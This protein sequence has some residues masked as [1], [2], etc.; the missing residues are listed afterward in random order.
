[1]SATAIERM[2]IVH[3]YSGLGGGAELVVHHLRD[4]LRARGIDAR[5]LTSTAGDTTAGSEPDFVFSGG[6]GR[7]RALREVINPS[8]WARLGRVLRDFDPECVYLGMF[9]TQASPVILQRLAKRAVIWVPNEFR[10]VCP[11]GTRLLPG[12]EP[13]RDP[14]GRACLA[15]GCFR[16]HGLAPRLAQLSLLHRWLPAIDRTLAPSRAFGETLERYGVRVDGILHR[17]V[18]PGVGR[19]SRG[20]LP[21][22][23]YA[24]RLVPEKGCDIAIRA[25]ASIVEA[26]PDARLL[27]AG[28]GPE[29]AALEALSRELGAAGNVEFA[30]FLPRAELQRR[31]CGR[32]GAMCPFALGRAVRPGRDRGAGPGHAGRGQ[33]GRCPA[34]VRGGRALRLPCAARRSGRPCRRAAP[35]PVR[36][37]SRGLV[38]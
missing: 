29:R 16:P 36:S 1:M 18:S 37:R 32:V 10:P 15:N 22:V 24:G 23:A 33:C 7:L 19:R 8:A 6:T 13:C 9:L 11:K 12:R 31:L 21:I 38:G 2:L 25:F 35:G 20:P 26:H 14:V 27:I 3:D 28:D 17:P 5:L 4:L 30:G 34:G